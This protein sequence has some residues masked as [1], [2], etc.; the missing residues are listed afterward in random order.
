MHNQCCARLSNHTA[1]VVNLDAVRNYLAKHSDQAVQSVSQGSTD[2]ALHQA[3]VA[4]G[5]VRACCPGSGAVKRLVSG[6]CWLRGCAWCLAGR[7]RSRPQQLDT[8]PSCARAT[9]TREVCMCHPTAHLH[10]SPLASPAPSYIDPQ[11]THLRK[12]YFATKLGI[13]TLD[14]LR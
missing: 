8:A 3:V 7:V 6:R 4:S 14:P 9:Y 5:E 13:S 12:S 11:V 1:Q 10:T 2:A